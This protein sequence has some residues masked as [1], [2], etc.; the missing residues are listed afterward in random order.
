MAICEATMLE[1]DATPALHHRGR[2]LITGAFDGENQAAGL[3][4]EGW[5][6]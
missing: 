6:G 2:S 3:S 1:Q 4:A 5:L